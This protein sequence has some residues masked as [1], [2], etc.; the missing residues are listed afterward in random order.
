MDSTGDIQNGYS[1]DF[2][3][4]DDY[5]FFPFDHQLDIYVA[6]GVESPLYD[7][8]QSQL[9]ILTE[10]AIQATDVWGVGITTQSYP[11]SKQYIVAL[12]VNGAWSLLE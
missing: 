8:S 9:T 1:V 12:A 3:L 4:G 11:N 7:L 5:A 2:Y 6:L 10:C